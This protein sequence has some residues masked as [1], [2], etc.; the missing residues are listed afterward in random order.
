VIKSAEAEQSFVDES[1]IRLDFD[2]AFV[3]A[4]APS[5]AGPSFALGDGSVRFHDWTGEERA[6]VAVHDGAILVATG[7]PDGRV[8]TGGDDGKLCLVSTEEQVDTLMDA[9][10]K[11]FQALAVSGDGNLVAAAFG[12]TVVVYE[13]RGKERARFTLPA[14]VEG[15]AFDPKG[16]RLAAAHYGGVSVFIPTI[17]GQTPKTYKW[18]GNHV[19]VTWS[20][21]GAFVVTG[22]QENALHGWRV[23]D[24]TDFQMGG[25]ARKVRAFAWLPNGKWLAT[26]GAPVVPVWP[27][28]SKDGPMGKRAE[29]VGNGPAP[30]MVLAAHPAEDIIACGGEDGYLALGRLGVERG[31]ELEPPGGA[32]ISALAW[33]QD[34][35]CLAFGREDGAAGIVFMPKP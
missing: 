13:T 10:G 6:C 22:M 32:A 4:I 25:Y 33:S 20:P 28:A 14:S 23:A 8:L 26:G 31:V 30:F 16:K 27:F 21:D 29:T 12:K 1:G 11:W 2:G 18:K 5:G 9:P 34:G 24:G 35:W 15:L 19:A 3:V 17:T 7:L